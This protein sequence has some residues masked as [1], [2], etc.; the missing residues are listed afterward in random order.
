M[1]ASGLILSR[2]WQDTGEGQLLEFWLA[3]QAGPLRVQLEGQE[4]VLFVPADRLK[5]AGKVLQG[6]LNYRHREVD[7][8]C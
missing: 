6:Q 4:S 7:L 5:P 8:R 3:T 1:I 2:H